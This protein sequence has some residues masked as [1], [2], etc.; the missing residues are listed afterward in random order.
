VMEGETDQTAGN[1]PLSITLMDAAG[2]T[3]N[4]TAFTDGNTTAVDANSPTISSY[5]LSSGNAYVDVTFSEGIYDDTGAAA[6]DVS[7]WDI[8]FTQNGGTATNVTLNDITNNSDAA[9]SGGESVIRFVLGVSGAPDG[10]EFISIIPN[11][12]SDV[13]DGGPNLMNA[14][15]TTGN[16]TLNAV[17]PVTFSNVSVDQGNTYVDI[18]FSEAVDRD[19]GSGT[20]EL[21][22][23]SNR[24]LWYSYNDV[25]GSGATIGSVSITETGGGALGTGGYSTIRFNFTV[26][27]TPNGSETITFFPVDGSEIYSTATEVPMS[28]SETIVANLTEKVAPTFVESYFFDTDENGVIDEVVIEM[29]EAMDET[30]ATNADFTLSTG[31][32]SA[33]AV[34]AATANNDLDVA[35]SDVYVTFT[36]SGYTEGT[37]LGSTDLQYVESAGTFVDLAGNALA[38]SVDMSEVDLSAPIPSLNPIDEGINHG[39]DDPLVLTFSEVVNI[40]DLGGDEIYIVRTDVFPNTTID[41]DITDGSII[42][43]ASPTLTITPE[44]PLIGSATYSIVIEEGAIVDLASSPNN[45]GGFST[46][47]DWNFMT[48]VDATAPNLTI[49][50]QD[51]ALGDKD[52]GTSDTSVSFDLYFDEPIDD[53]TFDEINITINI[54]DL[55]INGDATASQTSDN[56]TGSVSLVNMGDDQNYSFIINNIAHV[57]SAADGTLSISIDGVDDLA[58]NTI[59]APE[60]SSDFVFDHFAP[61]VTTLTMDALGT[62]FTDYATDGDE[63]TI[64]VVFD[65]DVN[66]TP[67]MSLKSGNAAI[68]NAITW[69]DQSDANATTW[70]ATYDVS[71]S[72]TDG[73]LQYTLDFTDDAGNPAVT[74]IRSVGQTA[75]A[76]DATTLTIDKTDPEIT[77]IVRLTPTEERTN[78]S[79]VTFRVTFNEEVENVSADGSDFVVSGAATTGG[80]TVATQTANT[81]FDVS[82]AGV[83]GDGLL[84]L[85]MDGG[86]DITDLADNTLG[87]INSEETYTVD[88]TPPT[89]N[90]STASAIDNV[91]D[92]TVNL[93]ESGSVHYLVVKRDVDG[94]QSNV[95]TVADVTNQDGAYSTGAGGTFGADGEITVSLASTNYYVEET[96][97]ANSVYDVYLVSEDESLGNVSGTVTSV[98]AIQTGGVLITAPTEAG[99]CLEGDAVVLGDIV[100]DEVLSTDFSGSTSNVTLRLGLPTGFEFNTAVGSVAHA[101]GDINA[102]SLD[103]VSNEVVRITFSMEDLADDEIDQ[104]TISDLEIYGTGSTEYTGVTIDRVG[105]TSSLYQAEESDDPVFATLSSVAPYDQMT[106]TSTDPGVPY[107][108]EITTDVANGNVVNDE[109]SLFVDE[110]ITG[111]YGT[112]TPITI[113]AE[114][115]SDIVRIYSDEGLTMQVGG[116]Y[117]GSTSYTPS[118]TNFGLS[119]ANLGINKFWISIENASG[120]E[121]TGALYAIALISDVRSDDATTL[122]EANTVGVDLQLSLP[123]SHDGLFSGVGLSSISYDDSDNNLAEATFIPNN[124]GVGSYGIDYTLSESVDDISVTYT[125]AFTV[126][127]SELV[128]NVSDVSFCEDESNIEVNDDD[129]GDYDIEV[130]SVA[131]F[132]FYDVKIYEYKDDIEGV[133]DV[134]GTLLTKPA[135]VSTGGSATDL[136]SGWIFDPSATHQDDQDTLI[137][138]LEMRDTSND[139]ITEVATQQVIIYSIP[140]V[141]LDNDE[142]DTDTFDEYYCATDDAFDLYVTISSDLGESTEV[143]SQGYTLIQDVNEDGFGG[144]DDVTTVFGGA[145][146]SFDP[147]DPHGDASN[148]TG[149]FRISYT[150]EGI[151]DAGCTNSSSVDFEVYPQ[152]SRPTFASDLS[153]I[154]GL[155]AGSDYYLLEYGAGATVADLVSNV[156]DSISWYTNAEKSV[157]IEIADLSGG[158]TITAEELYGTSSPSGGINKVF[159]FTDWT[160][161]GIDPD[162]EFVG[163]ESEVREV[164]AVVYSSPNAPDI[165]VS[166]SFNG[167]VTEIGTNRYIYEYCEGET[168]DDVVLTNDIS[169]LRS[170]FVLL[171]EAKDDSTRISTNTVSAADFGYTGAIDT[172]TTIYVVHIQNDSTYTSGTNPEFVGVFSDTTEVSF[173]LHSIPDQPVIEDFAD[174]GD[175]DTY[176]FC[177]GATLDEIET[178]NLTGYVYEWANDDGGGDPDTGSIITTSTSDNSRATRAEL[179]YSSTFLISGSKEVN[180]YH[181][182]NYIGSNDESGFVGCPSDDWTAV[183]VTVY[184]QPVAPFNSAAF[185]SNGTTGPDT[186]EYCQEQDVSAENLDLDNVAT[187]ADGV[188]LYSWYSSDPDG[189]SLTPFYESTTSTVAF[190]TIENRTDVDIDTDATT[191]IYVTQLTDELCESNS[192]PVDVIINRIPDVDIVDYGTSSFTDAYCNDNGIVTLQGQVDGADYTGSDDSWSID[193]GGLTEVSNLGEFDPNAAATAAGEATTQGSATDHDIT[194]SYTITATSCSNAVTKTI[195]VNPLPVVKFNSSNSDLDN[196]DYGNTLRICED[197]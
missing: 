84:D 45:F 103:Y 120:C 80:I 143:I 23:A 168:L 142:D 176:K 43:F 136:S 116:N 118:L 26:T 135:L 87:A 153:G 169:D 181:V 148:E 114:L 105:G 161:L 146:T 14:A 154:G 79:P 108:E 111:N 22:L 85:D 67:S 20:D 195:T 9:L 63:V 30:T 81:V 132:V 152:P 145:I 165:D 171:N 109:V 83:S 69:D 28:S 13:A 117:T 178:P 57:N 115:A 189:L 6:S 49:T 96:L 130:P 37:A 194:Y 159:Y 42:A 21:R 124:V 52:S 76:D 137:F 92:I 65:D 167:T 93:N 131:G 94:V 15:Q 73:T 106:I 8:N 97:D 126:I 172:D 58:G 41:I 56:V 187:S 62:T 47:D 98:T 164:N 53:G 86:N 156:N 162:E 112:V 4:V 155:D 113:Y 89:F 179:G 36:I 150:T 75:G 16:I 78:D 107:L 77:N 129:A 125:I 82:I 64:G 174:I 3:D 100:L 140:E 177:S 190:T 193:T 183:E 12:G 99:I 1:I 68:N 163:C 133:V 46:T 71:S 48:E 31:T 104:L 123:D 61:A 33:S 88:N 160:N 40:V 50:R 121:S 24:E 151:T 70:T 147:A 141:T 188:T 127:S 110:D 119:A 25:G 149:L 102:S 11:S 32:L 158:E 157:G 5:S 54:S 38:G 122:S 91:V 185:S 18:T 180:T 128:F 170:Y 166:G 10:N 95:P 51:T 34:N 59:A 72:D 191:R 175:D 17:T 139:A 182:R 60:V 35:D 27:G 134:S 7:D 2:N 186:Y 192:L 74:L 19:A 184:P 197:E 44:D 90:S 55:E 29:N 144:A 138:S 196:T 39:L 173:V 101:T 66:D